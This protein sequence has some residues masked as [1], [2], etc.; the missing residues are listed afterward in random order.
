MAYVF[1]HVNC[2]VHSFLKRCF[3]QSLIDTIGGTL[4]LIFKLTSAEST[5]KFSQRKIA[6]NTVLKMNGL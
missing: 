3:A 6:Q 2:K 1:V 4:K 5:P